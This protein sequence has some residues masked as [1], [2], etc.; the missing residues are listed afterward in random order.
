MRYYFSDHFKETLEKRYGID[1]IKFTND[2]RR[3]LINN[4]VTNS[5]PFE[6]N[7]DGKLPGRLV[8]IGDPLYEYIAVAYN[9]KN[10]TFVSALSLGSK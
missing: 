4:I 1:G 6:R 8:Y 9:P 2:I 7:P 5:E 3:K 10:N